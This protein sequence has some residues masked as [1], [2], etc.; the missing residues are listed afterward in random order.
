[1]FGTTHEIMINHD[2]FDYRFDPY[3]VE[4]NLRKGSVMIAGGT[5]INGY[6][7]P[8]CTNDPSNV[9]WGSCGHLV[10]RLAGSLELFELYQLVH[11]FLI[12]YNENDPFQKIERWNPD[13]CEGDSEEEPYCSWCDEYGH[14]VCDCEDCFWCEHCQHYEEHCSEDCPNRPKEEEEANAELEEATA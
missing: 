3:V 14:D 9:C 6:T 7:H 10:S 12:S 2:G 5:D 4:C 8:H 13:W 11:Q 1:V